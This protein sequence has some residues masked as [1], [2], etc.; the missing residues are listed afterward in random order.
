MQN[1]HYA[2][3]SS[4]TSGWES[5]RSDSKVRV[6]FRRAPTAAARASSSVDHDDGNMSGRTTH[7]EGDGEKSLDQ[8]AAQAP[9]PRNPKTKNRMDMPCKESAGL[10]WPLA[11][12]ERPAITRAKRRTIYQFLLQLLVGPESGSPE[13]LHTIPK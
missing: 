10:F 5:S 9:G 1:L 12:K 11:F 4:T 6:E 8:R 2:K 3:S 13:M 7:F